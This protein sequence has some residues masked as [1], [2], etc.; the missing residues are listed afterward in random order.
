MVVVVVVLVAGCRRRSNAAGAA[1]SLV[2][3]LFGLVATC[4]LLG[5]LRCSEHDQAVKL[6]SRGATDCVYNRTNA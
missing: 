2:S 3:V 5:S 1:V 6:S 4:L